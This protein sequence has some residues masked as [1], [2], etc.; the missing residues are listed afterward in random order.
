MSLGGLGE[1]GSNISIEI[2]VSARLG[3]GV[4][5]IRLIYAVA[6]RTIQKSMCIFKCDCPQCLLLER[7][8]C[9]AVF[10]ESKPT[11]TH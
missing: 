2:R 4:P 3:V 1:F 10:S 8:Y 7:V 5:L 9:T 6:F 11:P